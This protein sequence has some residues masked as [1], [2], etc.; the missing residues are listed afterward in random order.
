MLNTKN[1][2]IGSFIAIVCIVGSTAGFGQV[3]K[4]RL[5][6][7]RVTIQM[8][9]KPLWDV[10]AKLMW[11]DNIAIGFEEA[12]LDRDHDDYDFPTNIAFDGD[13]VEFPDGSRRLMGSVI[14]TIKHHLITVNF[15]NS[16]LEDVLNDIV[17]QMKNYAWEIDDDVVNIY[18][19]RGR[20]QRF[21]ELLGLKIRQCS[22]EKGNQLGMLRTAVF[23]L[24]EF[25][26]F[27]TQKRLFADT[28]IETPAYSERLVR[29]DMTF[30]DLTFKELLNRITS[31]KRGGWIMKANKHD[32]ARNQDS[33]EIL[34]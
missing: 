2:A 21:E 8:S 7:K 11:K 14:P 4:E 34:L 12:T 24:P 10:F 16:K 19:I 30:S 5:E 3:K 29:S 15:R 23:F 9:Q 18:P 25:K 28:Q 1:I 32:S 27:V 26:E 17:K 33:I 6:D 20:D 13:F 22:V 31:L